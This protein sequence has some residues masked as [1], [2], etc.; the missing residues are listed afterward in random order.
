[1]IKKKAA[2]YVRKWEEYKDDLIIKLRD[3]YYKINKCEELKK[4]R[5]NKDVI[6]A[7]LR[8]NAV[9][10]RCKAISRF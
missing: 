10:N 7:L 2:L 9:L 6:K 5:T 3:D 4:A 8:L 1:M